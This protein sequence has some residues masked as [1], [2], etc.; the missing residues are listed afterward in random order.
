MSTPQISYNNGRL[1][2]AWKLIWII[3]ASMYPSIQQSSVLVNTTHA[4]DC[5]CVS[6]FGSG[7]N[8]RD[9]SIQYTVPSLSVINLTPLEQLLMPNR[10]HVGSIQ[11]K[12]IKYSWA[13][14]NC[15]QIL[16]NIGLIPTTHEPCL[17][18]GKIKDKKVYFKQQVDD[19]AIACKEERTANIIFDTIYLARQ[20]PIKQQGLVT[21]FNGLDVL[22]SRWHIKVSVETY[23]T[24]TFL[25]YFNDWLDIPSKMK[26]SIKSFIWPKAIQTLKNKLSWL[27]RWGLVTER[28]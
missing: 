16:S 22:Q 12:T 20:M 26:N 17:Y 9:G 2:V 19:F 21:L 5:I 28:L 11:T 24:K 25:P 23:L 10:R 6:E 27:K 13:R 18:S 14:S 8:C 7:N 4:V 3:N 1:N 15:D